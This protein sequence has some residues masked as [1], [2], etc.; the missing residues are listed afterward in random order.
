MILGT[1]D[2]QDID[3]SLSSSIEIEIDILNVPEQF[4]ICF[5]VDDI[6]KWLQVLCGNIRN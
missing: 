3:E 6:G 4:E 1:T 2:Q 5:I